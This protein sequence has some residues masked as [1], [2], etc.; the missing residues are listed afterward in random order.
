M[1]SRSRALE[2]FGKAARAA[3]ARAVCARSSWHC[4]AGFEF[5]RR[6][7]T[8]IDIYHYICIYIDSYMGGYT[9]TH[10]HIYIYIYIYVYTS[11]IV[12]VVSVGF[13]LW[14]L[15]L[16]IHDGEDV[17]PKPRALNLTCSGLWVAT[18]FELVISDRKLA[19]ARE[20]PVSPPL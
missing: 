13:G 5:L 11:N 3:A 17:N 16:F 20:S 19:M 8:Y 6:I 9:H 15:G 4:H 10:T 7:H 18:L 14:S 1:S 12:C 2:G